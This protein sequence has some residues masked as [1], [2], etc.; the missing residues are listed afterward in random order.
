M[1]LGEVCEKI[2]NIKWKETAISYQ[3]IDLSSVDRET[4]HI[5]ES[6]TI[7]KTNAPSRAQ[8]ITQTDDVLFGT[9]RPTLNRYCITPAAYNNQI[10]STG[11]CVLRAMKHIV[12]PKWIYYQISTKQFSGYVKDTQKGASYPSI[13]NAEVL[14]YPFPLPP[15]SEQE[16]IVGILD[17]YETLVHNTQEGIPA[18]IAAVKQKYEYY[19]ERMLTF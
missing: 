12:L 19:R 7:D 14:N 10:C 9:T 17:K 13:T 1:K 16:R 8:Q 18:L 6:S 11:F 2:Y 4:H 15:L 3:Y 5:I